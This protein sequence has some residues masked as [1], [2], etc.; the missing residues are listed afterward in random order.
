M[1]AGR[2]AGLALFL[3]LMAGAPSGVFAAELFRYVNDDGVV[4]ITSSLPPRYASRGYTVLD[5]R[6]RV[7]R[8]VPRQLTAEEVR[9]RQEE[10][11]AREARQRAAERQRRQDEELLRRY[12]SPEAV[13][14][15]RDDR[16]AVIEDDIAAIRTSIDR[17]EAQQRDLEARAADLER[18]GRPVPG[19]VLSELEGIEARIADRHSDV[20]ERQEEIDAVH[21]AFEQDRRRVASLLGVPLDD[22]AGATESAPGD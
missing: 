9:A 18:A 20:R 7:I 6:G 13:V 16:V 14:R 19:E 10:E 4:V 11:A 2:G 17:L 3:V 8:E 22:P 21:E 15:A 12:G 5:S 1:T